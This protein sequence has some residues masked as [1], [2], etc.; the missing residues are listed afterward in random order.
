M[1]FRRKEIKT[2]ILL[3]MAAMM[4]FAVSLTASGLENEAV[5]EDTAEGA[6]CV[7]AATV[8]EFLQA[9]APHTVILLTADSYDLTEA[10]DYGGTGG[11]YYS[12]ADTYDGYELVIRETEDLTI[13]AVRPKTEI[14]TVPR[15]ACVMRFTD[16]HGVVLEGLTVGHLEGEGWCTGAVLH[17]DDCSR[18]RIENCELY[19][20]GTYGVECMHCREMRVVDTVIRDCSYGAVDASACS[21]MLFDCCTVSGIEG[22]GGVFSMKACRACALINSEVKGCELACLLELTATNDFTVAGC[23]IAGNRFEGMFTSNPYPVTVEGC[24]FADNNCSWYYNEWQMSAAAVDPAGEV[25]SDEELTAMQR[26][27]NVT[28]TPP[29]EKKPDAGPPEVSEDGMIHVRTVDELLAAIGPDA[30]IYLED[31][32]YDL[33]DAVGFGSYSTDC[34]YWMPCYDGP[35]LVICGCD[36]LR[37]TAA[38]PHRARIVA[39]PRY[40]EVLSFE[41]CD[42]VTLENFTAGHTE[43][44]LGGCEGGV[45]S[46][47]HCGNIQISDCSFFGCGILGIT[48]YSCRGMEVLHTEIHD[49]SAGAFYF[50]DSRDVNIRECNI[51]DIGGSVYQVYNCENVAAD[52]EALGEGSRD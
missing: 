43:P 29:S 39:V 7:E 40:A 44:L 24:H 47:V 2:L 20:C 9:I 51:H 3:L 11:A 38:G 15:Y 25:Y 35:G 30:S 27:K 17:F 48:S 36:G 32:V 41:N 33:S 12:W 22:F 31:G 42:G 19:G 8:D 21:N 16:C 1:R 50:C 28:W 14:L 49:C 45:L 52:G 13:R 46:F 26:A 23:E 34:Y 10:E 5:P 37:I 18:T 4:T 6:A